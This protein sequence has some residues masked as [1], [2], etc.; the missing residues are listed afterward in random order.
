M[1][2]SFWQW[3]AGKKSVQSDLVTAISNLTLLKTIHSIMNN[4]FWQWIALYPGEQPMQIYHRKLERY[5]TTAHVII[6]ALLD[7][8]LF[9]LIILAAACGLSFFS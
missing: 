4:S 6:E 3:M 2:N 8:L 9:V 5:W 1:N 7:V